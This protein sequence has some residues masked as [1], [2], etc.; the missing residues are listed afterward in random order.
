MRSKFRGQAYHVGS[1]AKQPTPPASMVRLVHWQMTVAL[2]VG[3][4]E[5]V[6]QWSVALLG[7]LAGVGWTREEAEGGQ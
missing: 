5:E 1:L 4:G 3:G 7:L 2:V 6:G